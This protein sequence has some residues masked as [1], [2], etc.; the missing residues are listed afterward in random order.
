[1]GPVLVVVVVMWSGYWKANRKEGYGIFI[2]EDGHL[3]EGTFTNDRMAGPPTGAGQGQGS[4]KGKEEEVL[5]LQLYVDVTDILPSLDCDV[6][7]EIHK[8]EKLALQ[9]N[10]DL[11]KLYKLYSNSSTSPSTPSP[12]NSGPST[13][14]NGQAPPSLLENCFT[15]SMREVS[16]P[17]ILLYEG[18]VGSSNCLS[19]REEVD[20]HYPI[21]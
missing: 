3:Y 13:T 19:L 14:T 15:M 7:A 1:M 16:T 8:L 11:K 4:R 21:A 10:T 9:H 2:F 12:S 5:Q 6:N 20:A 18:R 17:N